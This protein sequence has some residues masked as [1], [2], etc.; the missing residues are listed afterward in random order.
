MLQTNE[1]LYAGDAQFETLDISSSE[2]ASSSCTHGVAEPT[3]NRT[4]QL[5]S[6]R[7]PALQL[8]DKPNSQTPLLRAM[9]R[10]LKENDAQLAQRNNSTG[11]FDGSLISPGPDSHRT[12]SDSGIWNG[13][14]SSVGDARS[15]VGDLYSPIFAGV[16]PALEQPMSP[17]SEEQA[18]DDLRRVSIQ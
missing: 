8:D 10:G 3:N 9:A 16:Q 7:P 1:P 6:S 12:V 4:M 14:R 11:A 15:S 18:M 2:P 13:A 17:N 5:S